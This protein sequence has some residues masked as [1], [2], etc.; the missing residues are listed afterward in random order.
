MNK[1]LREAIEMLKQL[2]Y[3]DNIVIKVRTEEIK[4]NSFTHHA[5]KDYENEIV[6]CSYINSKGLLVLRIGS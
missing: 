4:I 6:M 3:I 5:I 1:T 2:H